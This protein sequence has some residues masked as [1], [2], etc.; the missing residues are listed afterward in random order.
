MRIRFYV[1]AAAIAVTGAQAS[2]A[3]DAVKVAQ[4]SKDLQPYDAGYAFM[5]ATTCPGLTLIPMIDEETKASD[6]FKRG[7][8]MFETLQKSMQIE[9]ACKAALNLFNAATGKA[10][11]L[12]ATQAPDQPT[13]P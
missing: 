4:N 6:S 10:A 7:V 5:A 11:R 9:G 1:L 8:A 13:K 12:L 3:A 2:I